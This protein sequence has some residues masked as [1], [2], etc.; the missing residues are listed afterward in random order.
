VAVTGD[1][2]FGVRTYDPS[3]GSFLQPDTYLG[4]QP[5]TQGSVVTDPL[6][7][8][9]YVYVNG[10]PLNLIDPS[11]HVTIETTRRHGRGRTR[12]RRSESAGR[13][14]NGDAWEQCKHQR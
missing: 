4:S 8:N 12:I 6:T 14:S 11:G 1:Y 7:R 2:Q 13:R 5:G 10:D 9:R 3:T